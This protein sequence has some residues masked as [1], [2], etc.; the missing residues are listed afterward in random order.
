[1]I[2]LRLPCLE[3]CI[4]TA[5]HAVLE[6]HKEVKFRWFSTFLLQGRTPV[7][8]F[9]RPHTIPASYMKIFL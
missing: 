6:Q 9:Q 3:Y 7:S 1:M 4:S 8:P 5:Q 2:H